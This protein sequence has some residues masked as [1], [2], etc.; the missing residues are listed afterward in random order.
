M[1]KI[2]R[3]NGGLGSLFVVAAALLLAACA[4]I[5][6]PE[7]GPR[8]MTP[9]VVV[10]STPA[11][12]SVNVSNGRID[13]VFDENI[14][15][16]DPMNK[17]VVSPPQKKQAQISSN[18]RRVR[19]TLR[20]TLRDSTTYTV[21]LADAVRD[22]NEGNILDGLAI[23]F[24]TGP[25]IDTLMISGIVF[26]GR[27]LEPAQGMIVGVYS[28]PVADTALTTLPMD[29][30][31]KTNALGRFTIRNLKPGSY[32]VF[33]INDLNHDFHWDRSEDI[34]FL[35][36]DISPSTMAVEVTDTFT[37]AAGNDS[38]VT[39]PA[40]R[41]LPD[42]ILLT[43]FNENY[44]PLYLVKHE[45][46]DARR[47]TLEMSTHSD[48]LPQLTLLNTV[49]AGARLD[50][51]AVLQSSPGLDSLTYWLRDTTLIG[52]DTLKI[53]ARYLHTDTLD[54]ITFTTDTL[55]FALRQ[56]KKKKKRDE[57]TDSVPK[58]EFVNIGISS[59]QPQDLNIPLLFETSAPT[60]SIDSAGFRIEVLVDSVWM[61]VAAR[62]PSPPDSLQ[63]MRLLT[64]MTWKPKTKYRVTID[65]LAVTDI[66]GNHNRPFV[67][68]V[69]THAIEDYAALF[70]NIGDLG[71]DS[72][73][74]ELLS[75]DKPVRLEPVRNGVATFEYVTPGA[76]Y[77][78]LF[79]D[80]NQN[81]RWDTGS[82]AD[83][84]QPEDVFYFSKKLNLKKNWDVE[85]QWNIYETPVDLQ[86]PEDI[87]K[88]KPPRPKWETEEERE[89][90]KKGNNDDEEEEFDPFMNDPFA[91]QSPD[92]LSNSNRRNRPR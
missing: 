52:S 40:T 10:S 14:T 8:D 11:P 70:F 38:L 3:H 31:T 23:D 92:R 81:G 32:R 5:G 85:Q 54:N 53:A 6:R 91:P 18:G 58:L 90:R 13:I 57:E 44:K 77:A 64:E 89:K 39:R 78:R 82:V 49:R 35:D 20:D 61:P 71:P 51:E 55:T 74:V 15:L 30:I 50:R 19:I 34:A 22:L 46:P 24:S 1:R 67:Q 80:R 63:P 12:G 60:A 42:D 27:T 79:I 26:E 4:S 16:D 87:K 68:E 33:A 29:R 83:T 88:N 86:K 7:G 17:I 66:Y 59:R 47:L 28:T 21:D 9:P 73:I 72:A 62:I 69:S 84:V 36:R 2:M 56:P 41:F 48:S 37:D 25:S 43:W 75:S 65:S 45:R 76:Y